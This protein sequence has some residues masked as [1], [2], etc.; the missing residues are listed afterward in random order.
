MDIEVY[1]EFMVLATHKSY[2]SASRDLNMSQPSLSLTA[3]GEV[4]L[5]FAGKIVGDQANM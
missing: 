1:R 3:A 5:R 4:V 2:V